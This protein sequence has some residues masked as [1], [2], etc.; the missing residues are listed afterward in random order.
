MDII[1]LFFFLNG[2]HIYKIT[3]E[4]PH[5]KWVCSGVEPQ[6][7]GSLFYERSGQKTLKGVQTHW[8]CTHVHTHRHMHNKPWI[9]TYKLHTHWQSAP[10]KILAHTH[11]ASASRWYL[12]TSVWLNVTSL[13]SGQTCFLCHLI[14]S[15]KFGGILNL[16]Q[17]IVL[18]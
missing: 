6:T 9:Y 12:Q 13:L 18:H 1:L 17:L 10:I 11:L 2:P 8:N 3:A 5:E 16:T 15:H 4:P 14:V 7:V